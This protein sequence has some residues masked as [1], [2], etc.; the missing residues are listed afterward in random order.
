LLSTVCKGARL[1]R[2]K[3]SSILE[4][5]RRTVFLSEKEDTHHVQFLDLAFSPGY[6]EVSLP[7]FCGMVKVS[8][9]LFHKEGSKHAQSPKDVYSGV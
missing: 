1:E 4:K 9:I 5:V 3:S 7:R 6:E 8:D 2:S